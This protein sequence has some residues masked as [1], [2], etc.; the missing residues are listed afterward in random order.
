MAPYPKTRIIIEWTGLGGQF[1]VTV[2]DGINGD[3][4]KA[5]AHAGY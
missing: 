1:P 4:N 3:D 2:V 5:V